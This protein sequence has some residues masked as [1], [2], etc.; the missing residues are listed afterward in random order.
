MKAWAQDAAFIAALTKRGYL[1][2]HKRV[3]PDGVYL[4]LHELWCDGVQHGARP[5]TT[6]RPK[7]LPLAT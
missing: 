5:A 1:V 7:R 4:Y 2:N 3:M 6:K